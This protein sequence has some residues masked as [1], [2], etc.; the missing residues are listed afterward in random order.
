MLFLDRQEEEEGRR[1]RKRTENLPALSASRSR[2]RRKKNRTKK[3]SH[4]ACISSS[5]T[6][7]YPD[8]SSP[9]DCRVPLS[10]RWNNAQEF[11]VRRRS[12][13]EIKDTTCHARRF[14]SAAQ[15]SRHLRP[16]CHRPSHAECQEQFQRVL[17]QGVAPR[18]LSDQLNEV[19]I[20]GKDSF[21]LRQFEEL[22]ALA[23]RAGT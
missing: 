23:S 22:Q 16:E 3:N 1:K 5:S 12:L 4:P 7:P 17:V 2:R 9:L 19:L 11:E 8:S 21:E 18:Q 6:N 10:S 15:H 14:D 20:V 13:Q